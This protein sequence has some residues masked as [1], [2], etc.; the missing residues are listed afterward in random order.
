MHDAGDGTGETRE[1]D[2][3]RARIREMLIGRGF[4]E[5]DLTEWMIDFWIGQDAK[6]RE[7]ERR[8]G[9]RPPSG[10]FFGGGQ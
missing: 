2:P 6:D 7:E 8:L 1:A 10:R 5:Q 4:T 9:Y 3:E